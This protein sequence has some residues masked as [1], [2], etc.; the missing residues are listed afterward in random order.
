MKE[1]ENV[2]DFLE[3]NKS[4]IYENVAICVYTHK[5][6]E[7]GQKY[8]SKLLP[9][10]TL[11]SLVL[12]SEDSIEVS[13]SSSNFNSRIV[14][15]FKFYQTEL[16]SEAI[17]NFAIEDHLVV[18]QHLVKALFKFK[19]KFSSCKKSVKDRRGVLLTESV[20]TLLMLSSPQNKLRAKVLESC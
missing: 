11:P 7:E 10:T 18:I 9:K 1:V 20:M 4:E 5:Q 2:F 8:T 6:L 15:E 13:P 19:R 3:S 17:C 14:T 16:D 12:T